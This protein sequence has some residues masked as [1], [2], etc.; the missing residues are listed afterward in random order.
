[1]TTTKKE[2]IKIFISYGHK[3]SEIFKKI[4]TYLRK[5]GYEVWFDKSNIRGTDDWRAEIV[6]GISASQTVI[7]GLSHDFLK[8]GGVCSE[9]MGIALA[10]KSNRIF[11]IYLDEKEDLKKIP[12]TL[13]R[14][15]YI[16]LSDWKKYIDDDQIFEKW[17]EKEFQPIIDRIESKDNREFSG[18]INKVRSALRIPEIGSNKANSYLLKKYTKRPWIDEKLEKWID[19]PDGKKIG[20]IYGKQGTG[21]SHYAAIKCHTDYRI[22]ASF[23]CEYNK[24][25]FSTSKSLI[26]DLAFQLACQIP[27]FRSALIN[28]LESIA[29]VKKKIND[30]GFEEIVDDGQIY[31]REDYSFEE[32]FDNLIVR[33]FS[34]CIDGKMENHL[35]LIDA[36]DEAGKEERSRLIDI[37]VNHLDRLPRWIRI[38]VLTRPEADIKSYLTDAF[39]IDLDKEKN[40]ND[41]KTFL[42]TSFEKQ[43]YPNKD[44]IINTIVEKSQGTF[45]YA[46]LVAKEI[47][48]GTLSIES[49]DNLPKGL[50]R[51]YSTWFSRIYPIE[52]IESLYKEKDR[53]AIAMILASPG[54]L[55]TVELNNL[56]GW[57]FSQTN[58]FVKKLENYLSKNKDV[59]GNETIEFSHKYMVD[60]L[61]SDLAGDYRVFKE[62]GLAYIY[63]GIEEVYM[64]DKN[65]ESMTR[66]KKLNLIDALK[67]QR[68]Q[69]V[70]DDFMTN[71]DANYDLLIFA[72]KEAEYF[73]VDSAIKLYEDMIDI[74]RQ[75]GDD[76]SC[77]IV[78][79]RYC[80]LL[81]GLNYEKKV[82]NILES[83]ISK[84]ADLK[85][86][87][88]DELYLI[89]LGSSYNALGDLY[90]LTK[91]YKEAEQYHIK[92][93]D[94]L[95]DLD[96]KDFN[97]LEDFEVWK[98]VLAGSYNSLGYLYS[99]MKS[100]DESELYYKKSISLYEGIKNIKNIE[101][102][103]TDKLNL[104]SSYNNL[105]YLYYLMKRYE[106]SDLYYK[107]A[108]FSIEEIKDDRKSLTDRQ[109][110]STYYN[111][112]G[113]LYKTTNKYDQSESSHKEA[114]RLLSKIIEDRN[115]LSDREN[116]AVYYNNLANL[117]KS[118]NKYTEAEEY[119]KS[120]IRILENLR[121]E[122]KSERYTE[123]LSDY[124]KNL[125][126][127]YFLLK[128]YEEA[129]KYYIKAKDLREE[130]KKDRNLLSDKENLAGVYKGLGLLYK[131]MQKFDD[132]ESSYK[133]AISLE[134]NIKKER[135]CLIDVE[136]LSNS[137]NNIG[138]LYYYI[139]RYEDYE[140]AY[141]KAIS[142]KEYLIEKRNSLDD[143]K[144]LAIDFYNLGSL[145]KLM[146]RYEDSENFYKKC[147]II[148]EDLKETSNSLKDRG[149][150]ARTYTE[151]GILYDLM[152]IYSKS[153]SYYKK[154]TI[155]Y[156]EIKKESN[157]SNDSEKLANSYIRLA[158]TYKLLKKY[159]ESEKIYKKG[160]A[161]QKDLLEK[162]NSLVSRESLS[163][164]YYNLGSIYLSMQRYKESEIYHKKAISLQEDLI[165]NRNPL[166]DKINLAIYLSSLGYLYKLIQRYEDSILYYKKSADL[167]EE[168][169]EDR[170]LIS[171]KE[172]LAEIYETL[173]SLYKRVQKLEESASYYKKEAMLYEEIKK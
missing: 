28:Q 71:Q 12:P 86:E 170:N 60:W 146:Q 165:E 82:I 10:I 94:L 169:K 133:K 145:Y 92:G 76:I 79:N 144:G 24:E 84:V 19:D 164:S 16:D 128:R 74:Y 73:R 63:K 15:Q 55:P 161:L 142:L 127:L 115:S 148:R 90:R 5:K 104:S 21:K 167:R 150:L 147:I 77:L 120:S 96:E 18:Q 2:K 3:E 6:E 8:E 143:K 171:D 138:N 56:L 136:R 81:S 95:K 98:K 131:S 126:I 156:E 118:M 34:I 58:D 160:I 111:N 27:D 99:T 113:L 102:D 152:K 134:E 64:L 107:K 23:F 35:I 45:L 108:I 89:S 141:K 163:K 155:L 67:N 69:K 173:G 46:E 117:Y 17:F 172:R 88:S 30:M 109:N 110:L 123:S 40:K 11:T 101:E 39:E 36:L 132:S 53:K 1:M 13:T 54:S 49:I 135:D 47:L 158:Y 62:D 149:I 33:P 14:T 29:I 7:A 154:A 51:Y 20:V 130:L 122:G 166:N 97:D 121:S 26:R 139:K 70:L 124:Y 38:L 85:E 80:K 68:D 42:E 25:N 37:F 100:Y 129:E 105:G 116:L 87:V 106:E 4:V 151:L 93:I 48:G 114:I 32:E 119:Y 59:D 22:A 103:H 153:V 137:Y 52:K 112:L 65:L 57:D 83:A 78:T 157:R 41:I 75:F 66:Y 125:G 140:L 50:A 44:E 61:L 168:Y 72:D 162:D 31:L 43:T 9:E 91:K 159:E